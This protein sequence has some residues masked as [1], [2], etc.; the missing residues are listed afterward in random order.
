MAYGMLWKMERYERVVASFSRT[1]EPEADASACESTKQ[2]E[3]E[4]ELLGC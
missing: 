4:L 3:A 2:E 1:V